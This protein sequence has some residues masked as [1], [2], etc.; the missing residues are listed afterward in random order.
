M[1][2]IERPHEE[3]G[4]ASA[5]GSG[6]SA[7]APISIRRRAPLFHPRQNDDRSDAECRNK[8]HVR[9]KAKQSRLRTNREESKRVYV[10]RRGGGERW[11]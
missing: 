10:S 1:D 2:R 4:C 11:V 6:A 8:K 5:L 9:S 7:R 3:G